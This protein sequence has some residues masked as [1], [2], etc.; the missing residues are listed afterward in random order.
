M[1]NNFVAAESKADL[2]EH[3][4]K[5]TLGSLDTIKLA[6]DL[7]DLFFVRSGT[8]FTEALNPALP[9]DRRRKSDKNH[10]PDE[11]S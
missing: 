10:K 5:E 11:D 6:L 7:M 3:V 8:V 1:S 4:K 9:L 2:P